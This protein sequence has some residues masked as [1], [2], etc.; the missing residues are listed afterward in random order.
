MNR[1]NCR[2]N[3]TP[4]HWQNPRF[5]RGTEFAGT[6]PSQE[7]NNQRSTIST[8]RVICGYGQKFQILIVTDVGLIVHIK[9]SYHLV[10]SH[11][12]IISMFTTLLL[13]QIIST[14]SSSGEF[15]HFYCSS[16]TNYKINIYICVGALCLQRN[17]K[18]YF[19]RVAY[20]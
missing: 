20:K 14:S 2:S 10:W 11:M 4:L 13:S 7:Q 5:F 8:I 6:R 15:Y 3:R 18:N 16:E 19:L 17:K 9:G 1:S 12:I